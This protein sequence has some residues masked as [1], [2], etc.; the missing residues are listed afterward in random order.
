MDDDGWWLVTLL[1]STLAG[2]ASKQKKCKMCVLAPSN[3]W[4]IGGKAAKN[5]PA[6]C[7]FGTSSFSSSSSSCPFPCCCSPCQWHR[8]FPLSSPQP[9]T[10]FTTTSIR[11]PLW[12]VSPQKFFLG[13]KPKKTLTTT[14]NSAP[15][16][17]PQSH[18]F[19]PISQD[20]PAADAAAANRPMCSQ[21]FFHYY[22]NH[23]LTRVNGTILFRVLNNSAPGRHITTY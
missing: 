22:L 11:L 13:S 2:M 9:N 6:P 4:S 5:C 23:I 3:S 17:S 15:P 21:R 14:T 8:E 16:P 20:L 10:L 18:H 1:T 12:F 7:V 19:C